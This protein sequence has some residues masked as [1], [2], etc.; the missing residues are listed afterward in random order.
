M[1]PSGTETHSFHPPLHMKGIN[2][3]KYVWFYIKEKSHS[4]ITIS[5]P[6]HWNKKKGAHT[7]ASSQLVEMIKLNWHAV[8]TAYMANAAWFGRRAQLKEGKGSGL[9]ESLVEDLSQDWGDPSS[10]ICSA[11]KLTGNKP[12]TISQP[13]LPHTIV[14]GIK[15]I[16]M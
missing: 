12:T 9:G 1:W 13:S 2:Q 3:N 16:H 4:I 5:M 14:M 8:S 6:F 10:N 7:G 15:G 11:I